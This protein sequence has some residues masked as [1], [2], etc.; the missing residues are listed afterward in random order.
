VLPLIRLERVLL[1]VALLEER[2]GS[3]IE[4]EGLLEAAW[5]LDRSIAGRPD[6][7]SQ[8]IA[9]ANGRYMA[10]A[11]R[12]M[13]EPSVAWMSRFAGDEPWGLVLDAF[14]NEPRWGRPRGMEPEPLPGSFSAVH[15]RAWAAAADRLRKISPCE[16][17]K[18]SADE[19]WRPAAEEFKK[20]RD[21]G[22]EAAADIFK[23][24]TLPNLTETLRKA[25]RLLIDRELTLKILQLRLEKA[26]SRDGRWP[27]KLLDDGSAIC[28]GASYRYRAADGGM[29]IRFEGTVDA[30]GSGLVLPL[31]FATGSLRPTPRPVETPQPA[32]TP[33]EPP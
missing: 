30:P 16:A 3:P 17:S 25:T 29:E 27:K 28:P 6:M 2:S 4:A 33:A 31:S 12:K 24:M 9:T 20:Y 26:G 18:L 7:M 8:I 19:I 14:A 10:G 11:L 21:P 15:A 23:E 22:A 1:T 13:K 32:A 5:S